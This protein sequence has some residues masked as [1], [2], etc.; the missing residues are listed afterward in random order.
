MREWRATVQNSD[1]PTVG[2]FIERFGPLASVIAWLI[3]G[4]FF[5]DWFVKNIS[6]GNIVLSGLFSA[7]FGWAAIQTGF[8]FSVFGFVATK[9]DGFIGEIRD[10]VSM[11]RFRFYVI[12][13]MNM[14]FILT[15]YSIPLMVLSLDLNSTVQY[16][17]V[18]TWFASFIWAF[19]S[20]LRVALNFGKMV[21][22]RD[23]TFIPG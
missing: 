10:T 8:L 20:F 7:V 6:A 21:S 4:Y 2:Y 19:A 18:S 9:N 15:I 12:K 16:W 1:R 17:V 22:V 5:R 11:R 14:G 13:A 23:N 3:V